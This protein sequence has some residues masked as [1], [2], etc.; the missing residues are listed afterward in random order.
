MMW[1]EAAKANFK[2]LPF[3]VYLTTMSVVELM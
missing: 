3:M 1:K 2:A